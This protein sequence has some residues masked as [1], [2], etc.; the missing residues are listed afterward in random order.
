MIDRT[1][2]QQRQSFQKTG[3]QLE[4]GDPVLA[5]MSGY[6]CAW[7]AVIEEFTKDKKRMKCYFYGSHNRGTVDVMKAIPFADAFQSIRLINLRRK[8]GYMEDFVRGV[9]ELEIERGV[10][11]NLSSLREFDSIE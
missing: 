5:Q 2:K 4:I 11:E 8:I 3:K 6:G 9:K 1:F 7:P 10:P